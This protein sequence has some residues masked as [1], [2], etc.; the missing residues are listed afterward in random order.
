MKITSDYPETITYGIYNK[1]DFINAIALKDGTLHTRESQ[2][3]AAPCSVD[4][5][6]KIIFKHVLRQVATRD[7]GKDAT[8]TLKSDG[9]IQIS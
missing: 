8:V 1:D 9:A 7:V 3:W 5:T 6:V 2:T 4:N